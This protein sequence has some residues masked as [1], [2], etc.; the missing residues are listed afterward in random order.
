MPSSR[1]AGDSLSF[2]LFG[3]SGRC[4]VFAKLRPLPAAQD[5]RGGTI[6]EQWAKSQ[7]H[8]G[9]PGNTPAGLTGRQNVQM[10]GILL[11][12]AETQSVVRFALLLLYKHRNG[13][14]TGIYCWGIRGQGKDMEER[15]PYPPASQLPITQHLQVMS[16]SF[17]HLGDKSPKAHQFR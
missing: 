4:S 13:I 11:T 9:H 10:R 8:Q 17:L 12:R 6:I 5:E 14:H 1:R 3:P 2:L 15:P 7:A 16:P